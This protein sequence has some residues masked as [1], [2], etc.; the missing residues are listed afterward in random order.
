MSI[1]QLARVFLRFHG[2]LFVGTTIYECMNIARD[3]RMFV[4]DVIAP[5]NVSYGKD[6]FWLGI[7]RI[8]VYAVTA[9]VLLLKTDQ[10]ISFLAGK[11]EVGEAK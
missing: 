11:T 3:Y 9:L 4:T 10:I 2:L 1:K 5:E 8:A 6:I 7:F